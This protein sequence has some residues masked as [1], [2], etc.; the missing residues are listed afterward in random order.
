MYLDDGVGVGKS[1]AITSTASSVVNGDI[2]ASGFIAHPEKCCWEPT[3]W[4]T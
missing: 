2:A 4:V 1:Y 3:Q